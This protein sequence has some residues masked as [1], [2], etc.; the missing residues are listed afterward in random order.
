MAYRGIRHLFVF[1]ALGAL[2]ACTVGTTT[3]TGGSSGASRAAPD[4]SES[5]DGERATD[6]DPST[7]DE[8]CSPSCRDK[9][10]GSDGCGGEC[11]TCAGKQTCSS[12]NKC[13]TA[14][15]PGVSCPPT[16][17]VGTTIGKIAKSGTLP[18]AKGGTYDLRANCAKPIYMLGVTETCGICMQKLGVWTKPGN[19]LD[20]LKADGADVVLVSTDNPQGAP[21]SA[22]TAEGLR[23]RFALGDRF[24]LAYEPAGSAAGG[25]PNHWNGFIPQRTSSSGARIALIMK[26]GNVIGETGQ[27]DEPAEIR[28]ALG[29]AR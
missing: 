8:S 12:A 6:S 1:A 27:I 3:V 28:A 22:G 14:V 18:L 7:P 21:G 25:S 17:T 26:P 20:Q 24:I 19:V 13:E 9:E 15:P 10:C 29:L 23:R 2:T 5:Q 16:G 11:G 4:G